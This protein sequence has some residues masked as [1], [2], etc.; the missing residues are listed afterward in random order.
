[1]H[2]LYSTIRT[3]S[4]LYSALD[5]L[6]TPLLVLH[7]DRYDQNSDPLLNI[8]WKWHPIW[9]THTSKIASFELKNNFWTKCSF[10]ILRPVV[11][12]FTTTLIRW[13]YWGFLLSLRSLLEK[14]SR[15]FSTF[16][17]TCLMI[18]FFVSRTFDCNSSIN[19]FSTFSL[20]LSSS[21]YRM[22]QQLPIGDVH[23]LWKKY[24]PYPLASCKTL[25]YV[26]AMCLL[27]KLDIS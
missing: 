13:C 16:P 25:L 2:F 27:S 14:V 17:G 7:A 9:P 15:S 10:Y 22:S 23:N 1:M 11:K 21:W 12:V 3:S 19:G 5:T 4:K 20:S 24:S 26:S 8:S 6:Q 18:V